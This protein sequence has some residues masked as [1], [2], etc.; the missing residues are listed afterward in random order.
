MLNK[1]DDFK[2]LCH[3]AKDLT[4]VEIRYTKTRKKEFVQI[5]C[6]IVNVMRRYYSTSTL[7]LGRLLDLHHSTIIH[8]SKDHSSRYRF[9]SDYATLYD[10]LVRHA[11]SKSETIS[12]EKMIELMKSALTTK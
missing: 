12:T 5:K 6:A 10:K 9:E 11:M 7:Q 1:E 2:E 3:L 4:G 8:H